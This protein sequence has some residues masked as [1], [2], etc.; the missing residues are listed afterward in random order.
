MLEH[1][2]GPAE[3][4]TGSTRR[5]T[6]QGST[7]IMGIAFDRHEIEYFAV[8]VRQLANERENEFGFFRH[9][10]LFRPS[11][12]RMIIHGLALQKPFPGE[13]MFLQGFPDGD[14]L[15][16]GP[17]VAFFLVILIQAGKNADKGILQ[18]ILRI[19]ANRGIP[20]TH[21]QKPWAEL[22]DQFV[23][24]GSFFAQAGLQQL[25]FRH[26][27][28]QNKLP[29]SRATGQFVNGLSNL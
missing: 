17:Q 21:C 23:L 28:A 6:E 25:V 8:A 16:P 10:D 11:C 18:D 4:G 3:T 2:S 20:A 14:G 9:R 29:G 26:T 22:S 24:S 5:D 27:A 19:Q 1:L 13:P 12:F 7:F 15:H